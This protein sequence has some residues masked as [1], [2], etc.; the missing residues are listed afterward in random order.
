MVTS[1]WPFSHNSEKEP[2]MRFAT[3]AIRVG[4]P[5]DP[6]TRAVISPIHTSVTYAFDGIEKR[7][8]YEYSRSGNPTRTALE[9]CLAALEEGRHGLA[10]AS[11]SAATDAALSIL[12]PGDHVVAARHL[13]GGTSR[14]FEQLYR[15]R[16]IAFS[17]V[18]EETSQAYEQA[19]TPQTKIVWIETPTNP[20]LRLVDIAALAE[21]TARHR[22]ALVVDN[23]FATPWL[24]QPLVL[25]ADVVVHSTTKYINGHSDVLG[26]AIVTRRAD[27]HQAFYHYQNAAGAVL[28]PFDSWLTLRGLKTLALRMRQHEANAQRIAAWLTEH[29]R[30]EEAIYPGLVSHPHHELA[31]RQMKGFGGIVTFRLRGERS[32]ADAFVRAL[33]VFTFAESLGGVESLVCH[34]STMSHAGLTETE[35]Q[36]MGVTQG[37][38]RLSVGIE[39]IEDLIEDLSQAL[40]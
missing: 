3:K 39:D 24:Q 23:T 33:R 7:S 29:P 32:A 37:T 25:G 11:G 21:V 4:Q 38:L 30:V 31:R 9:E 5:L 36:G 35:R 22:V 26:G 18:D 28:G 6:T 17:Y 27:L 8:G 10:F 1:G 34:P 14:I 40:G 20:L 2:A 15:P 13:Y 19:L 16:G 12:R